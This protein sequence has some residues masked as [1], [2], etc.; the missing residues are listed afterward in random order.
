[1]TN[2]HDSDRP[3]IVQLRALQNSA[4]W[5]NPSARKANL[6][7]WAAD[8]IEELEATITQIDSFEAGAARARIASLEADLLAVSEVGAATSHELTCKT[9]TIHEAL[10]YL[11]VNEPDA[12]A[13]ELET[14]LLEWS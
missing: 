3:K 11:K 8:R 14:C 7:I 1:M 9:R 4:Q 5:R 2:C 10:E 12:A 6:I 13:V